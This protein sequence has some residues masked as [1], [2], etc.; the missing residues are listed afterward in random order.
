M[1]QKKVYR[2]RYDFEPIRE[3]NSPNVI[4]VVDRLRYAGH[5]LL[6]AEDLLHRTLFRAV[7][8]G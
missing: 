5:V 4:G 3:F 1:T 2:S 7:L 6:G 8:K